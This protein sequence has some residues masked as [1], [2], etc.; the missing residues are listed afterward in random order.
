MAPHFPV[1]D[2]AARTISPRRSPQTGGD[3]P[4]LQNGQSRVWPSG[5]PVRPGGSTDGAG[6]SCRS[7]ER[8]TYAWTRPLCYSR[9]R[10]YQSYYG[11]G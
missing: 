4:R 10:E 5:E 6:D 9:A 1:E 2:V 3:Y 11:E 7:T 8:F